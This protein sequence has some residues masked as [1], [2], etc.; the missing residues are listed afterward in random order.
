MK[1]RAHLD[2]N[3]LIGAIGLSVEEA[4]TFWRTAFSTTPADK[5]DK[6][7]RYNV[8]HVY[9]L[10]GGRKNYR[11]KSCQQLL[12]ETQPGPGEAH[13]CPYRTFSWENLTA[14]LG[15]QMGVRDPAVLRTVQEDIGN[16]K[17]HIACNRVFEHI[18]AAEMKREKDRLG[19]AATP[20]WT[21]IHPNEYFVRSWELKNPDAVAGAVGGAAGTRRAGDAMEVDMGQEGGGEMM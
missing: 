8:R 6:D 12:T 18:H 16:M 21:I 1:Y 5:F 2:N 4:L 11:A 13:G 15:Q 20:F 9:G 7:Y 17:Y 3:M 10:E 14:F 19:N